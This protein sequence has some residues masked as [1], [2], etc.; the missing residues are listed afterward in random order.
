[1]TRDQAW[2]EFMAANEAYVAA[3]Q[4]VSDQQFAVRHG[5]PNTLAFAEMVQHTAYHNWL[6]AHEKVRR[7]PTGTRTQASGRTCQVR[8]DSQSRS[9]TCEDCAT[10][11]PLARPQPLTVPEEAEK[12]KTLLHL[13][14]RCEES[15]NGVWAHLGFPPVRR[16]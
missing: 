2:A 3:K 10:G 9:Y 4:G 6:R 8:T 5:M 1:M 7:P 12:S 16:S 14:A 13:E 15:E 11:C